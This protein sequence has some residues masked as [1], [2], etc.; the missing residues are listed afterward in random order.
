MNLISAK[1]VDENTIEVHSFAEF[2]LAEGMKRVEMRA[3]YTR[4]ER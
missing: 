2:L 3:T 1:I 4:R